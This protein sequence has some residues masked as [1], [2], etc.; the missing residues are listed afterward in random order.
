MIRGRELFNLHLKEKINQPIMNMK[1][2]EKQKKNKIKEVE[3]I[4]KEYEVEVRRNMNSR[5]NDNSLQEEVKTIRLS[6]STTPL[7]CY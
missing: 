3:R 1:D 7:A 5:F 4:Y 2:L 6:N